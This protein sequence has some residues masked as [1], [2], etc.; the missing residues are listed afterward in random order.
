MEI[1]ILHVGEAPRQLREQHGRFPSWFQDSI[2]AIDPDIRWREI[3]VIDG[4]LLP[5]PRDLDAIAITGSVFGVHDRTP[6]IDRL[7]TFVAD[8]FNA[9]KK[10]VGICFGHQL[11]AHVLGGTVGRSP[12]GWGIGLHRYELTGGE[13]LFPDGI[14]SI[15]VPV[16]HQDQVTAPPADSQV[17]LR[18]SFTPYA[19]LLY[20]NGV[21]LSV[22][23][24]PEFNKSIAKLFAELRRGNP[25]PDDVV[26]RAVAGLDAPNDNLALVKGMVRFLRAAETGAHRRGQHRHDAC[27]RW[28]D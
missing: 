28:V 25:L 4:E 19:G 12:G 8:A 26:N 21:G 15:A 6:W 3:R 20:G 11:M 23:G 10:M 13:H 16:S 18:S 27:G 22:Q 24:H 9:K 7:C 1:A 17:L 5:E 2:N 14:S